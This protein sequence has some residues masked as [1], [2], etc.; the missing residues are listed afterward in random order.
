[1]TIRITSGVLKP[2]RIHTFLKV[3]LHILYN[4]GHTI[5]SRYEP[6]AAT[7]KSDT[8]VTKLISSPTSV[9]LKTNAKSPSNSPTATATAGTV[10]TSKWWMLQ[11]VS[12]WER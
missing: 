1:M 6:S 3:I 12:L 8:G 11:R 10:P 9:R 7:M 2:T 4:Q 5:P